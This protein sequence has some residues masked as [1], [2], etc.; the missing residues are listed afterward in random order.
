MDIEDKLDELAETELFENTVGLGNWHQVGEKSQYLTNREECLHCLRDLQICLKADTAET[1]CK[2]RLQLGRW[3]VLSNHL[4]PLFTSYREDPEISVSVLRLMVTL[5]SRVGLFD[6]RQAEHLN[7]LQD[8]KEAFAK[9]DVFIILMGLLVETMEEDEEGASR[10][11]RQEVFKAVLTL[12]RQLISVPDPSPGEQ[13]YTPL[14]KNLQLVY[15]KHFHDEGVLD[16]FLLFADGLAAEQGGSD[17]EAWALA[18]IIYHICTHVSPEDLVHCNNKEKHKRELASLLDLDKAE[19]KINAAPTSRHGRFGTAMETRSADGTSRVSASVQQV[20]HISKGGSL[21]RR[22]FKN[23]SGSDKK[24]NM[25]HNPFFVDLEEGAVR[26]HNQLNPHLKGALEDHKN[27]PDSVIRGLKKFFEEFVQ[28]SFSSLVSVWRSS[29][30]GTR[31]DADPIATQF[32]RQHLL[33]MVSWFLEFH[34]HNY[35]CEANK[36]KKAG[37]PPHVIDIASIQGAIDLDIIQ[38]TTARLRQYGKESN[39][40]ASN[41]VMVL[42]A[43]CQQVK[44]IGVCMESID[45]DT[46]DCGDVLLQNIVKDDVLAHLCWIMKNFSS[47]VHDPRILSYTVE[48][49]HTL[50]RLMSKISE[51]QNKTAAEFAVEKTRGTH[52]QRTVTTAEK[53]IESLA[54]ARV[55][56]NLFH[57]LEKY[58]RHGPQL[59]SMLVKLIYQIVRA[60]PTNIVV[61]FEMSY[62]LRINRIMSDPLVATKKGH[63]DYR[64]MVSLLQFILRQ[65]FKCAEINGCVFAEV[66]F[67][68]VQENKAESLLESHTS[69]FAA[70]LDNYEDEQYKR[71]L[72]RLGAG[73]TLNAMREQQRKILKGS[74]PWTEAEDQVL[75][76]RYSM[77]AEHPL[78]AELL[79]AEL[80]EESKRTAQQVR[81]RLAELE[82]VTGRGG[83]KPADGLDE[84]EDLEPP[85][86]KAKT[87]TLELENE[88]DFGMGLGPTRADGAASPGTP[89]GAAQ[90]EAAE[91]LEEDLERLLDAAMDSAPTGLG[92]A[93]AQPSA[94][95][96][97]PGDMDLEM[98]LEALLEEDM[99]E[100]RASAAPQAVST[101]S[102]APAPQSSS[103]ATAV[104]PSL[105]SQATD[106][107][108]ADLER[109]LDE[110]DAS[111]SMP[112]P[113]V[114][115]QKSPA[116]S[117]PNRTSTGSAGA[118][119]LDS[120][121]PDTLEQDLERLL[122]EA[123]SQSQSEQTASTVGARAAGSGPDDVQLSQSKRS[124][125]EMSQTGPDN[126]EADL[127]KLLDEEQGLGSAQTSSQAGD[128]LELDLERLLDED[129]SQSQNA[130][131][132]S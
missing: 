126:L 113:K 95:G 61:F 46:R 37:Q 88:D 99:P 120:Q 106:S 69:E 30:S 50:L 11:Y 98:E 79:A 131:S 80:P 28:T 23:R 47:S 51:R 71:I 105:P 78:A 83:G 116:A 100:L 59:H 39:I 24:S 72:D 49:F 6:A 123:P 36:A 31:S 103:A 54:D 41:L 111:Q 89:E 115:P 74:L 53:E 5:T 43:L 14:R 94:S 122:D 76:E 125:A 121:E 57:L 20:T 81:K 3:K 16:F 32:Q 1:G 38:F 44:T 93:T 9:K 26:E 107:L 48:V 129:P 19:H 7:Q 56:E 34:R 118:S 119:S 114:P 84:D 87:K 67:R 18:E 55:V 29:C 104:Q 101:S 27:H 97:A 60:V 73:D 130:P 8:Y 68:K 110:E 25:F 52:I 66:L 112:P 64:E 70:I 58:R 91:M 92:E 4:V 90:R 128:S 63:K 12:L 65:F 15:I 108:E 42:R 33:N 132:T 35:S 102:S 117:Q 45:S 62:F 13:G 127:E 85:S 21:W 17:E 77:Y 109:L 82:L 96:P 10:P 75:R 86:K 22:E 40:H 2:I 124:E